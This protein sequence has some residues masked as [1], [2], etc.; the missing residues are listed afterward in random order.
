MKILVTRP[1]PGGDAT[2]A[3]L[4]GLGH[5]VVLAPLLATE[6]VAWVP[7]DVP[8]QAI[9]LT[10]AFA[11]RLAGARVYQA[12]PVFAV[13]AATARAA[14]AAG[15]GDVRDCGGTVQ[16]L[17][18]A[19]AAAGLAAVLHLAGEDRTLAV[20]P[21]GL[22]VDIRTVYRARLLPLAA[23]PPVD[24]VLLYSP[25]SAGHF[26]AEVNRL[27][28]AR[29][30]VAIAAISDGARAAAGGGWRDAVVA[31]EPNEDMLLAAIGVPCQ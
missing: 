26:A 4:R 17:L 3:R 24:W 9:M 12:L 6:A 14:T 28:M 22:R 16:V 15:F 18:D 29:C 13:G 21:A 2:A 20:I 10:S 8:P 27:G 11:A 7:P 31:A 30:D 23:L 1:W 5:T 19:M 25:R